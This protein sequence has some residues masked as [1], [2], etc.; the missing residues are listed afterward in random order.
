M[1]IG[2]GTPLTGQ[3]PHHYNT[4]YGLKAFD[5]NYFTMAKWQ[6]EIRQWGNATQYGSTATHRT[7]IWL[8]KSPMVLNDYLFDWEKNFHFLKYLHELFPE[9]RCGIH[10]LIWAGMKD[11]YPQT[12]WQPLVRHLA[13][14]ATGNDYNHHVHL[15]VDTEA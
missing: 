5:I 13:T 9:M 14:D 8:S 3:C 10:S 11:R 6:A 15:H 12:E 4:H 7:E 1:W 2:D